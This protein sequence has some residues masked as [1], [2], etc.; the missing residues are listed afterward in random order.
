MEEDLKVKATELEDIEE[1]WLFHDV[2]MVVGGN[3][4]E[5]VKKSQFDGYYV[6]H[7]RKNT[8]IHD[9]I[10]RCSVIQA[11]SKSLRTDFITLSDGEYELLYAGG[12]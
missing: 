10:G 6:G 9:Q 7:C 1:V 11:I 4:S 3:H 8:S 5:I 12:Y 2:I